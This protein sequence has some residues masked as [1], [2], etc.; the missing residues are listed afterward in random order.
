MNAD[1]HESL[2]AL[3]CLCCLENI[4]HPGRGLVA[5]PLGGAIGTEAHHLNAGGLHG[6]KRLGDDHTIPLC[7]WHHR[8]VIRLGTK[9]TMT[10]TY[11]PSWA[12]GSKPFR[13]VYGGDADLLAKANSL[14]ENRRAA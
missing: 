11:G 3:G 9:H 13:L 5:V 1:R 6:G 12:G 2:M 7:G 14:I 8:G 4:A 10:V